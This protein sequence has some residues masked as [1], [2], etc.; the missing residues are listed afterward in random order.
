MSEVTTIEPAEIEAKKRAKAE[1]SARIKARTFFVVWSP[2]GGNPVVRIPNFQTARFAA[3]R[4]GQKHPE[5]QFYVLQ[6]QWGREPKMDE[7]VPIEAATTPE[8]TS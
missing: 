2:Q 3:Y 8:P 5:Q 7:A 6:S 4:L 1:R